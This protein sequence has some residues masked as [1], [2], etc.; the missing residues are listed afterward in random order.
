[1]LDQKQKIHE[2][3][4]SSFCFDLIHSTAWSNSPSK[5]EKSGY[6]K[7]NVINCKRHNTDPVLRILGFKQFEHLHRRFEVTEGKRT[8]QGRPI[9]AVE[10]YHVRFKSVADIKYVG[11]PSQVNRDHAIIHH[12]SRKNEKRHHRNGSNEYSSLKQRIDHIR[13]SNINCT[14]SLIFLPYSPS[15]THKQ[16]NNFELRTWSQI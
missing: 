3:N 4:Y 7:D 1:M 9:V 10:S 13:S 12:E 2:W 5:H 6:A 11:K 14:L 8:I 16:S 15:L